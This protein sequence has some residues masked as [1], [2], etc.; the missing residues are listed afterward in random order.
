[1]KLLVCTKCSD[2]FALV[3]EKRYC[4]CKKSWGQYVGELDAT[5]GGEGAVPIAFHNDSFIEALRNRPEAGRGAEFKA[6]IIPKECPT[7]RV[8]K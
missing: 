4:L 2:I 5:V 3:S 8:E 6:W 1:V 7:V